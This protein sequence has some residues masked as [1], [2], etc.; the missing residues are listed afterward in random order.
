[1]VGFSYLDV[2]M[3]FILLSFFVFTF[4]CTF[5]AE[6]NVKMVNIQSISILTGGG[7][8]LVRHVKGG[9]YIWG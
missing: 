8:T 1:M 7:G 3:K 9:T 6:I 5:S 2:H 4:R